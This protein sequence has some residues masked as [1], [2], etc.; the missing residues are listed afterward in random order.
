MR[1]NSVDGWKTSVVH[2]LLTADFVEFDDLNG[3]FILK[4]NV[5]VLPNA[6]NHD[7][8]GIIFQ[9]LCISQTL[10]LCITLCATNQMNA[11]KRCFPENMLGEVGPETFVGILLSQP[12]IF[13]HMIRIYPLPL[14][15]FIR[16]K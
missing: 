8:Y 7:V 9:Y 16:E 12:D 5:S 1:G 6:H 13:V 10:R 4:I 15:I 2:L 14:D 3:L 11:T